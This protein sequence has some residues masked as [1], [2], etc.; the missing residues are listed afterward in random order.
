MEGDPNLIIR[1]N[2]KKY[3]KKEEKQRV[4]ECL[5]KRS[6][7]GDIQYGSIKEV[8]SM[9][10]VSTRTIRRVWQQSKKNLENESAIDL[11][12][13]RTGKIGRKRVH[14]S[15]N[16]IK[17]IPLNRRCTIRSLAKAID[18]PKTTVHRRI[19]EGLIRPHSNAVKPQLTEDNKRARLEFCLSH[20][21]PDTLCFSNMYNVIH[22]DE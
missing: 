4:Y 1:T 19:Q 20:L 11:S 14:V 9:F 16:K 3:L 6:V 2:S 12:S 21:D 8:A 5:L 7:G 15:P 13:K 22:I 18:V 17:Q 10:S